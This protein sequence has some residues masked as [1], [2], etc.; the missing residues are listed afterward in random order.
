MKT[1]IIKPVGKSPVKTARKSPIRPAIPLKG[2]VQAPSQAIALFPPAWLWLVDEAIPSW[3]KNQYSPKEQWKSKPFSKEDSHFFFKG[4]EEL[5][6]L[7][8][9]ERPKGQPRYFHHPRF[10]SSYLLY[11]L[12][13]QAAKFVTLFHHN[14]AALEAA[15]THGRKTGTLRVADLGA[16][17]GT[18]SISLLLNLLNQP[19]YLSG[20]LELPPIHFE[21][22]DTNPAIME[23]GKNLV[24]QLA[25]GFPKLRGKVTVKLNH[26][27]WWKAA[28]VISEPLSLTFMGH[29]LNE[30]PLPERDFLPFWETLLEKNQGG[31][32]LM[33][34]PASRQ[35]AQLL[36]SYRDRFFESGL[37]P[38]EST[39][40]WGPC[41]HAQACPLAHGR[42]WCHFSVPTWIPGQWFKEFSKG[43]GSER[44][45]V[46]YSYLWIASKE[47]P[48]PEA[49]PRLRRVI[50]DPLSTTSPKPTVLICEP[51]VAGRYIVNG[52]NPVRRG[53]LV[54]K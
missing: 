23:D 51:E 24:E 32:V 33:V 4:I 40:I 11:F 54:L 1:K 15:L 46:K 18:A 10:R 42:D 49:N 13:L 52:K 29:V 44:H 6:E 30:S 38:A 35:P 3:V 22:F 47:F 16:G 39:R 20:E 19:K 12:P 25:N 36:S 31:G 48:A 41:L 34:E 37:L 43:L 21:W 5:S 9:E 50:S 8:T 28:S 2:R 7:F 27:P 53:D 17:P 26:L 45:W 14:T